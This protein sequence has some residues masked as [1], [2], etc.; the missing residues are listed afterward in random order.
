MSIFDKLKEIEARYTEL[1]D[2]LA[3]PETFADTQQYQK[4]ARAHS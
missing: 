1:T 2:E 3:K 4:I